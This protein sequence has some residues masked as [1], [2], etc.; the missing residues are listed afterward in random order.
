MSDCTKLV[1]IDIFLQA[2]V[3][4][5]YNEIFHLD[6]ACAITSR[7]SVSIV[8]MTYKRFNVFEVRFDTTELIKYTT[9]NYDKISLKTTNA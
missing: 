5:K 1:T 6:T 7:L 4:S 2:D 9:Q 8:C 3:Y